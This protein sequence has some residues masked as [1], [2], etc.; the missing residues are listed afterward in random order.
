M[1]GMCKEESVLITC[2]GKGGKPWHGLQ[3]EYLQW[4]LLLLSFGI[5]T[6][7]LPH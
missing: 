3:G 4:V 6:K 1:I 7:L 2:V 5:V